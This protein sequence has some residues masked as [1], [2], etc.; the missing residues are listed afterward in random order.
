MIRSEP[1]RVT[2][3]ID[4]AAARVRTDRDEVLDA[5]VESLGVLTNEHDVDVFESPAGHDRPRGTHVRV[6]VEFSPQRDVHRAIAS[7][8]RRL[9]RS[10]ERESRSLDGFDR[11]VRHRIIEL[12]DRRHAGETPIPIELRASGLEDANCRVGDVGSDAV[13][14]D[15]RAGNYHMW[16]RSTYWE[17]RRD[18][19]PDR[20]GRPPPRV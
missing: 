5:G 19:R 18:R 16:F 10:L 3:A 1:N 4:S 14:R 20:R 15:Q 2:T 8:H 9:E 12:P 17:E 11:F 13:A 7:A 6:Q